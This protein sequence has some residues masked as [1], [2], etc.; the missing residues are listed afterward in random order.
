MDVEFDENGMLTY[1]GIY[2]GISQE[3]IFDLQN[4]GIDATNYIEKMYSERIDVIR[5]KKID[6]ILK[7]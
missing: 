4:Y 2:I 5:D 1:K 3:Q 7:K 6:L